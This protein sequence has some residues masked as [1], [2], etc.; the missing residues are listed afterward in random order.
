MKYLLLTLLF[1]LSYLGSSV[2]A[3]WTCQP[4]FTLV[5]PYVVCVE[6]A[7]P[8][9]VGPGVDDPSSAITDTSSRV[10]NTELASMSNADKRA[11]LFKLANLFQVIF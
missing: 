2:Q 11:L 3:A 4:D 1:I 9:V 8:G 7:P 5:D 6:S 10:A